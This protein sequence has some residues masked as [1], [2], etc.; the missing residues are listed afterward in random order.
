MS[1]L[2]YE[3]VTQLNRYCQWNTEDIVLGTNLI[4]GKKTR[5]GKNHDFF[6]KIEKIDLID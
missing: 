5:V 2:Q 6:E 4:H 1:F 3:W